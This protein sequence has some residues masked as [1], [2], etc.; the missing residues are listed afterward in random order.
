MDL[1]HLLASR[2]QEIRAIAAEVQIKNTSMHDLF[3]WL[4]IEGI[5]TNTA[6]VFLIPAD[7]QICR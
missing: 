3:F 6:N 2:E 5:R 7:T 4:E 1:V